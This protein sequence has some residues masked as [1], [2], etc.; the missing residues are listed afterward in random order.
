MQH[1]DLI[2]RWCSFGLA[3]KEHPVTLLKLLQLLDA[4]F[5]RMHSETTPMHD[6]EIASIMPQLVNLSGSSSERHKAAFKHAIFT[7]AQVIAP[8]KMCQQLLHGLKSKN[9]KSRVVCLE[10]MERVVEGVGAGALGRNGV[11]E[12]GAFLDSSEMDAN[13]RSACLDLLYTI[14]VSLGQEMP[15]F[16]SLLGSGVS[17]KSMSL[18]EERIKQKSKIGG[19]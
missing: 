5:E 1:T 4:V 2:F 10:E 11:K 14:Y 16:V 3:L 8:N 15:K 18:I 17:A 13:S 6:S 19:R 7:A 12:I 9:K